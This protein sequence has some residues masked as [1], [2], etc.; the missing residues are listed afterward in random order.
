[1]EHHRAVRIA[2]LARGHA[3]RDVRIR[4]LTFLG[5]TPL[6]SHLI[7]PFCFWRGARLPPRECNAPTLPL[8]RRPVRPR[9][10]NA[11]ISFDA[12]VPCR[13]PQTGPDLLSSTRQPT[14]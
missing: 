11:V 13:V 7:R 3:E 10:P 5:V 1:M 12:S 4:R 2:D 14:A 6:D 8:R 9:P